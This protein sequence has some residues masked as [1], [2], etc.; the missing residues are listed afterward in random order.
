MLSSLR[1]LSLILRQIRAPIP[2]PFQDEIPCPNEKKA[3]TFYGTG[4]SMA[5]VR[6]LITGA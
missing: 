3:A 4:G 5:S 1:P 2:L 6:N